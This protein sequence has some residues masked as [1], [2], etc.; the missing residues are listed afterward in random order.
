MS[1]LHRQQRIARG[2]SV[3]LSLAAVL[4]P[5]QAAGQA[6]AE[7]KWYD[8]LRFEGDFRPRYDLTY[9]DMGAGREDEDVR[10]RFRFRL[11]FGVTTELNKQF[12]VGFRLASNEGK[13]PTSGNVTF[14]SGTAPKTIG[15]DRAYVT[16]TPGSRLA[17]TAGKFANVLEKPG[18]VFRSELIWDED[19]A[20]EGLSETVTLK[21][22]SKGVLRRVAVHLQQWYLQEFSKD[23]DSWMLGGQLVADL[24]PSDRAV[25]TLAA[26]YYDYVNGQALAQVANSND[27]IIVSNSVVLKD[28]TVVEGGQLLRP[29][30]SNPF[31]HYLND[32]SMV[33]GS[34]AL[35]LD[36]VLGEAGLQLYGE[37]ASN[38]EADDDGL[39][40]QMG[41]GLDRLRKLPGWSVAASYVRIEQE[42]ALS[43][44]SYSDL[45]RG[46]TNQEGL[47]AQVQYRPAR[48]VTFGIREHIVSPIRTV[49]PDTP[50]NRLQVDLTLA[51]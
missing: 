32:F 15:L 39:A 8:R 46:G 42:A 5:R 33:H 41:V 37:V 45:G 7:P 14:G 27:Q 38:T 26:G 31:D 43:M 35:R 1:L 49:Q 11:R 21:R 48:N 20:P 40:V 4:L 9:Q 44:F 47:I 51:F 25:L 19:L 18:A 28:G 3:V 29:S 34:A 50:V 16:W 36:R 22:A 13:N 12:A 2:F 10:G 24:H 17:V 6:P 23:T 30:A